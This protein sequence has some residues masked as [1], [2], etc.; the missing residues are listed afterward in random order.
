MPPA[1]KKRRIERRIEPVKKAPAS[2]Q[3][4]TI[5]VPA[6]VH[7][8]E[9]V[10]EI[11]GPVVGNVRVGP[12]TVLKKFELAD[13]EAA[14]AHAKR[15]QSLNEARQKLPADLAT[16]IPAIRYINIQTNTITYMQDKI[17]KAGSVPKWTMTPDMAASFCDSVRSI[18]TVA[19]RAGLRHRD[20]NPWNVLCSPL[21]VHLVDWDHHE[22]HQGNLQWA[23]D[24]GMDA[25]VV[26]DIA[27]L[28]ADS[29]KTD[30]IRLKALQVWMTK[31]PRPSYIA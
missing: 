25:A 4:L 17:P 9:P 22:R 24:A 1:Q 3:Q 8:G 11:Y 16:G 5:I 20:I 21:G 30:F 12:T 28:P 26:D 23:V 27:L 7:F 2:I 19:H 31:R 13:M 29:E 18:L 10:D 6:P 15:L 14:H